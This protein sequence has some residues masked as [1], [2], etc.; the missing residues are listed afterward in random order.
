MTRAEVQQMLENQA[1]ARARS[2]A[3][4]D[5]GPLQQVRRMDEPLKVGAAS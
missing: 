2:I 1:K 5:P 3:S 4:G